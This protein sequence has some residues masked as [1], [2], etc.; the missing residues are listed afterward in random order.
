MTESASPQLVE[1]FA[2]LS[3][4][5]FAG[6]DADALLEHLVERA[7]VVVE[8]CEFASVSVLGAGGRI[9]TPVATDPLVID[10]DELQYDTGPGPCVEATK[11][12]APAVYGADAAHDERWPEFGPA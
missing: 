8:G 2:E 12:D 9:H 10:V 5:L 7:T 4:A 6:S 11:D 1:A 3:Q